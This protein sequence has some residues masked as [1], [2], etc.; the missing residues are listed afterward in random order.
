M[1]SKL[2]FPLERQLQE[3]KKAKWKAE[4]DKMK[5]ENSSDD[6]HLIE[7]G[8]FIEFLKVGVFFGALFRPPG[9]DLTSLQSREN[10]G[11]FVP[12][13]LVDVFWRGVCGAVLQ[14]LH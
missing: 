2:D 9:F 14:L 7:D 10:I 4:K 1:C 12:S 3:E 11:L 6:P 8:V 5:V 13:G